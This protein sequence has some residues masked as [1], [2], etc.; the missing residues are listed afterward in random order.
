MK[1]NGL[2]CVIVDVYIPYLSLLMFATNSGVT[3]CVAKKEIPQIINLAYETLTETIR[4]P[5]QRTF[6][7]LLYR[8]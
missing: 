1:T 2:K 8:Q 3:S 4:V 6:P 5:V 7:F